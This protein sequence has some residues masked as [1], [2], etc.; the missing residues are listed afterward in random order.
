MRLST[1]TR[2]LAFAA[3]AAVSTLAFAEGDG[4]CKIATK[5][6][7]LTAKACKAGGQK[8]ATK[9]MKR[10]VK[11]AKQKGVKFVCDDCHN[12]MD[13]YKLT[14]NAEEDYKK[15]VAAQ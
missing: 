12:N 13:D 6:D 1:L 5:G 15:L 10:M 7:S 11:T 8:A 14:K 4:P 2:V 9:E 3:I